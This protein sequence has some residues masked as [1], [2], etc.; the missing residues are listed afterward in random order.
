MNDLPSPYFPY[1]FHIPCIRKIHK[2]IKYSY[3]RS[4]SYLYLMWVFFLQNLVQN[5]GKCGVCGDPYQ[6][7]LENEA[8]GKYANGIISKH[9]DITAK[10]INVT[11]DQTVFKKGYY[12]FRI[13]PNNDVNSRVKQE[14]LDQYLLQIYSME[15]FPFDDG[16][17][18]KSFSLIP[19]N[20]RYFPVGRGI[21]NL[22]LGIPDKLTCIQ[23]VL[24]WKYITGKSQG[25]LIY[26]TGM[27]QYQWKYI[28]CQGQCQWEYITRKSKCQ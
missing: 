14:C 13:C 9:Y 15:F 26:I 8:G 4:L 25:H 11:I 18:A 22:R 5:G 17:P 19:G 7:P 2:P 21:H 16:K 6:G 23:C 28:T 24:Q 1:I 10:Y 27:R 12:E 20:T 3:L